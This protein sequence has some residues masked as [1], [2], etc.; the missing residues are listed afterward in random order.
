MDRTLEPAGR[1]PRPRRPRRVLPT[2]GGRGACSAVMS[3]AERFAR[4]TELR[5]HLQLHF[6]L[7]LFSR[8][9]AVI[10]HSY[11]ALLPCVGRRYIFCSAISAGL[12]G[13]P[14]PAAGAPPPA[15]A[16]AQGGG[17]GMFGG[18]MGSVVSA[19]PPIP[20]AFCCQCLNSHYF[21]LIFKLI[22]VFFSPLHI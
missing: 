19:Q 15:P 1:R 5:F 3:A 2:S 11:G 16:P 12:R 7:Q 10:L 20:S 17:G 9:N 13:A 8:F 21:L 14:P 18:L 22:V 6:Q 4:P